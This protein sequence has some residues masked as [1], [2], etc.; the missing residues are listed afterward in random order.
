MQVRDRLCAVLVIR[1]VGKRTPGFVVY[2]G[3]YEKDIRHGGLFICRKHF[4]SSETARYRQLPLQDYY[5][6]DQGSNSAI[7][8]ADDDHN[9]FP[10]R[11]LLRQTG[12]DYPKS[13]ALLLTQADRGRQPD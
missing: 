4:I 2:V 8:H 1:F 12:L 11:S 3:T 6:M 5:I 10:K 9:D 7:I 13:T